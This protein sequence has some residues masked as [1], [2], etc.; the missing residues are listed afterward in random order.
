[1]YR[2]GAF[3][4]LWYK[5]E[6]RLE[7]CRSIATFSAVA[8]SMMIDLIGEILP[9][10]TSEDNA[11]LSQ[12]RHSSDNTSG[13]K[14]PE[15]LC[16]LDAKAMRQTFSV[17]CKASHRQAADGFKREDASKS[18]L[19]LQHPEK[20]LYCRQVTSV[21]TWRTEGETRE[22][23]SPTCCCLIQEA[24][25]HRLRGP[26]TISQVIQ[27]RA[28]GNKRERKTSGMGVR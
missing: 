21:V 5:G 14:K 26:R 4:S 25:G 7:N 20:H 18:L 9:M 11:K 17:L 28:F 19:H 13:Q 27:S 10:E 3:A 8:N 23:S 2:E 16:T 6:R 1:M 15:C 12:R 24:A 22:G